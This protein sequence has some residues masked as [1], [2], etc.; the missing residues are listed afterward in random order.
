MTWRAS[1]AG[2]IPAVVAVLVRADRDRDDAL[3]PVAAEHWDAAIDVAR[4]PG[5]ARCAERDY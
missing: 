5:R 4:Q 2:V 1:L 3:A